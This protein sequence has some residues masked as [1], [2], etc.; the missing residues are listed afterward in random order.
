MKKKEEEKKIH[1]AEPW[2]FVFHRLL[3]IQWREKRRNK[4]FLE[5]LTVRSIF[6]I[7]MENDQN[8]D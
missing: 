7:M 3:C 2:V 1:A 8:D 4:S 5:Q 6:Y